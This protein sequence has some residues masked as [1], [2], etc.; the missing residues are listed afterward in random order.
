MNPM[1][2]FKNWL[3]MPLQPTNQFQSIAPL[4]ASQSIDDNVSD[5]ILRVS[6]QY[7]SDVNDTGQVRNAVKFRFWNLSKGSL[8]FA[9]KNSV[10]I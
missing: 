4:C 6:Y 3:N 5:E 2:N 9:F 10:H 1:H 8:L 7:R